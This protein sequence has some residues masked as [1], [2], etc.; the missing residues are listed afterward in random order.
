MELL[1]TVTGVKSSTSSNT[2]S[3]SN[4]SVDV[5]GSSVFANILSYALN[6]APSAS[7]A[8][9]VFTPSSSSE[10]IPTDD[11]ST[12]AEMAM[13][14]PSTGQVYY[15]PVNADVEAAL[16]E[17]V[18][19]HIPGFD[20]DCVSDQKYITPDKIRLTSSQSSINKSTVATVS[21]TP[22]LQTPSAA[23]LKSIDTQTAVSNINVQSTIASSLSQAQSSAMLLNDILGNV[24]ANS[25]A[26]NQQDTPSVD[27]LIADLLKL[28]NTTGNSVNANALEKLLSS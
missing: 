7:S 6:N 16:K 13:I 14:D 2:P 8:T 3:S 24:E 21:A 15:T 18:S 19:K 12:W 26:Q 20:V 5:A 17:T 25:S 11:P 23:M 27:N 28:K 22:S 9:T 4:S 1:S 10:G